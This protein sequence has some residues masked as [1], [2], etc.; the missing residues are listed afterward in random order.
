MKIDDVAH[1]KRITCN[2]APRQLR[3]MKIS[4][5]EQVYN[6]T[7]SQ[8]TEKPTLDVKTAS[9]DPNQLAHTRSIIGILTVRKETWE[10]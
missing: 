6:I 2:G 5:R 9:E 3:Y 1:W 7:K 10:L 4:G 8:D